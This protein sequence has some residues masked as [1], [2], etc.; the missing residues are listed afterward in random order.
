MPDVHHVFSPSSAYRHLE[1]V[2][3]LIGPEI[4]QEPG[5]AANEG[6]VCHKLL[7]MS[8][9]GMEPDWF[10]G[11]ELIQEV[12]YKDGSSILVD[13]EMINAVRFF[14][15][16]ADELRAE[17]G[18]QKENTWPERHLVHPAFPDEVFGGTSDFTGIDLDNGVMLVMDLKYGANPVKASSPQL[19][20]YAF[21][22]MSALSPEDQV[23]IK[24]FVFV[25]VQPRIS[26]GDTWDRYEPEIE[27]VQ[28]VWDKL[29]EQIN[30]YLLHRHLPQAPPEL[31]STG[32]H[33]TYCPRQLHCPA[34]TRDMGDMIALANIPINTADEGIVKMLI[35]WSEKADAVKSFLKKVEASL[36]ELASRGV[37]IPGKK[38]VA[39]FG[40]R[41]WKPELMERGDT[42]ILRR[43]N[44]VLEVPAVECKKVEVVGPA[45]IEEYLRKSGRWKGN[46]KLQ[47]DFNSFV[48]RPVKGAKL[49]DLDEPGEPVTPQIANELA[50][51]YLEMTG[52]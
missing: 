28:Q 20:E 32:K 19:F 6:T 7:E 29:N 23:K 37:Q 35:Y 27:E 34:I 41:T 44:R 9:M 43:L 12:S 49:V 50:Q 11:Q 39:S 46:R 36:H 8:Q 31:L 22:A 16:I 47:E 38:L 25:I 26:Y 3:Y 10:T 18:I 48:H 45:K 42:Y 30:K 21:L 2:G 52:E 14:N 40:N 15:Q 4:T 51:A 1:C 13:A 24:R 17:L 5:D 33:C